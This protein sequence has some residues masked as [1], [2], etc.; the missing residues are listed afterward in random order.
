VTPNSP[1][2]PAAAQSTTQAGF[3]VITRKTRQNP[4]PPPGKFHS[5]VTPVTPVTPSIYLIE[6]KVV[7]RY[8]SP[9]LATLVSL[10]S[11]LDPPKARGI[12]ANVQKP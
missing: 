6:E 5:A 9:D 10:V 4:R 1:R 8:I 3:R 7:K 11:R 2:R 12:C